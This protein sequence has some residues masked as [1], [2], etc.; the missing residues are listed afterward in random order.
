MKRSPTLIA[1]QNYA[2]IYDAM[3]A[4]EENLLREREFD[5]GRST[6]TDWLTDRFGDAARA[7]LYDCLEEREYQHN[8]IICSRTNLRMNYSSST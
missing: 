8:E 3:E 5:A 7:A 1:D 2:A 4:I 6:L